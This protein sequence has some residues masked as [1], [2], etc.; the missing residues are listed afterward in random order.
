V[1]SPCPGVTDEC[2]C[3]CCVTQG[4]GQH[5]AAPAHGTGATR[6]GWLIRCVGVVDITPP[7]LCRIKQQ[8]YL[9]LRHRHNRARPPPCICTL[10]SPASQAHGAWTCLIRRPNAWPRLCTTE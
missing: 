7:C 1:P 9:P 6:L 8:F 4:N 10:R 3:C 2:C 5:G